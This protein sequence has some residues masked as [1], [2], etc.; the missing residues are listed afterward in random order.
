[1]TKEENRKATAAAVAETI[2]DARERKGWTVYRL[3]KESG[4]SAGHVFR[5]E[6]GDVAVRVDVLHSIIRALGGHIIIDWE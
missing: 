1:M 5:I 6:R 2:R 4:L 3:A